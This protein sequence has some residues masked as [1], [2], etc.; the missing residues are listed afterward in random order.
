MPSLVVKLHLHENIARKKF[1]RRRFFLP[2]DQLDDLFHGHEDF[3]EE[4]LFTKLL[5]TLL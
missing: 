4:I 2:F 3:A 1:P 5:D